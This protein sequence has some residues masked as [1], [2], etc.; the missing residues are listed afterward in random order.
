MIKFD[1]MRYDREIKFG[2]FCPPPPLMQ[3]LLPNFTTVQLFCPISFYFTEL[4]NGGSGAFAVQQGHDVI[5]FARHG[6]VG[7]VIVG[8]AGTV[9]AVV[10]GPLGP[11]ISFT[12]DVADVV[13]VL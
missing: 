12:S 6:L 3:S 10:I 2:R 13:D 5:G 11:I 7:V 9:V 1:G 8:V 4:Q